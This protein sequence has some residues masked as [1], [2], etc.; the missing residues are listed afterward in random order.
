MAAATRC[1]GGSRSSGS[2]GGS[3]GGGGIVLGSLPRC[4]G[5]VCIIFVG[6]LVIDVWC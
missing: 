5:C 4:G 3:G 2:V 6:V 1:F